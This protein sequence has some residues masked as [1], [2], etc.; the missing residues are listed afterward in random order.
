M[1]NSQKQ[2]TTLAE[3]AQAAQEGR[4]VTCEG[5]IRHHMAA[6]FMYRMSGIQIQRYL[7]HGVFL[8][9][10]QPKKN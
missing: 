10:K 9:E 6:A 8:Y 1:E 3:L 7:T 5:M 2:I 4:A